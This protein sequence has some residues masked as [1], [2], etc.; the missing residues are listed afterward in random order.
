[1]IRYIYTFRAPV[2]RQ[3]AEGLG[4]Q[5]EFV[6]FLDTPTAT[7]GQVVQG[8]R[9]QYPPCDICYWQPRASITIG[10]IETFNCGDRLFEAES[11]HSEAD[12]HDRMRRMAAEK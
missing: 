4:T 2:K 3:D 7:F 10:G 11:T 6:V 12:E 9:D 8:F 1:M 5:G